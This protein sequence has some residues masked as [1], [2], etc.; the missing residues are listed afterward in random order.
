MNIASFKTST[1]FTVPRNRTAT[2][3]KGLRITAYM[4][5]A[6]TVQ[7]TVVSSSYDAGTL[8][9]TVVVEHCALVS[10]LTK[11]ALGPNY[12]DPANHD[13]NTGLHHHTGNEDGG[14]IAA[15]ELSQAEID[16]LQSIGIPIAGDAHK[17]VKVSP[18]EADG[19]QLA[20]VSGTANRI[21]VTMGDH[22]IVLNLPQDIHTGASPNFAGATLAQLILSNLTG[23]LEGKGASAVAAHVSSAALQIFR[24]KADNSG[25][26]FAAINLG[27][28]SG[29]VTITTVA[30]GDIIYRNGSGKWVNLPKGQ[31]R[32]VLAMIDGYPAWVNH[33]QIAYTTTTAVVTTT[34]TMVV[35]TTTSA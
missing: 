24:R 27:D 25:Y 11:V 1:S 7:G 17:L 19:F 23:I 26:E 16:A 28:L 18:D 5:N 21:T 8:L 2:Y 13:S 10:S 35:T 33:N 29:D 14:P 15:A 32:Q 22:T 30:A 9:T 4:G 6:G 3:K 12:A 31:N 20:T 34:T